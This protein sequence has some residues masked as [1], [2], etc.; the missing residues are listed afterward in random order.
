[1]TDWN[2]K[3]ATVRSE[4]KIKNAIFENEQSESFAQAFTFNG[5]TV[6]KFNCIVI[7]IFLGKVYKAKSSGK[8]SPSF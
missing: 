3:R 4:L 5:K 1:M 7:W 8:M 2:N 6:E